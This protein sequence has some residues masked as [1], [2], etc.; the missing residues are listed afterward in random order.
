MVTKGRE[1][2]TNYKTECWYLSPLPRP[3]FH[4]DCPL[5][6]STSRFT[7]SIPWSSLGNFPSSLRTPLYFRG[8][9]V[10][11]MSYNLDQKIWSK[12]P[13][14]REYA[15]FVCLGLGIIF[16]RSVLYLH[17]YDLI[18][19]HSQIVFC[20]YMYHICDIH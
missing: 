11:F 2:D 7:L 3:S 19:L 16:S 14:M 20:I 1:A 5:F 13:Q 8:F 12:D 4:D 6:L 18:F 9:G 15:I 10:Y 17:I